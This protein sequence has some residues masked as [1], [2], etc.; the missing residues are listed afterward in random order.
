MLARANSSSWGASRRRGML[1]I[2]LVGYRSRVFRSK[3]YLI[4][5]PPARKNPG[6]IAWGDYDGDGDLDLAAA[7]SGLNRVYANASGVLALA[8]SS[9]EVESTRE[10]AWGDV[11]GDG[12]LDLACAN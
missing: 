8:W 3:K 1:S 5:P 7:N 4:T 2:S 6:A 11:D 9:L 10:V 12:D